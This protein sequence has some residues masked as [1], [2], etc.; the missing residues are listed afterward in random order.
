MDQTEFELCLRCGL[1]PATNGGNCED[2]CQRESESVDE[3]V[4]LCKR[5]ERL[6]PRWF[7]AA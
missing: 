7:L 5:C 1:N 4:E 6:L 2:C 3:N